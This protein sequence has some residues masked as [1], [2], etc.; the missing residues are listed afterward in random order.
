[1]A[2]EMEERPGDLRAVDQTERDYFEV[3]GGT[4][5]RKEATDNIANG[6]LVEAVCPGPA[7][8]SG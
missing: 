4:I 3:I 8:S 2:F 5:A 1:M 6:R 7:C